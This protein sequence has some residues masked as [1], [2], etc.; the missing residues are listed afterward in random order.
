LLYR[1]VPARHP[2]WR[3]VLPGALFATILFEALKTSFAFYVANFNNFDVVYG[4]LAG[5][6][7]FLLYTWLSANI[8]LLGAELSRTMQRYWAG[9]LD[10]EIYPTEAMPP[11]STRVYRA[12]RALFLRD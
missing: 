11:V 4:S 7:L 12:V 8:L 6:L 5:I 1:I 3:D 10:A 9:D 2:R